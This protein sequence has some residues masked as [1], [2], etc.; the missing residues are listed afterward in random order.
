MR[1]MQSLTS[2][3]EFGGSRETLWNVEQSSPEM[4]YKIKKCNCWSC[5]FGLN[6]TQNQERTCEKDQD[7]GRKR[8]R[9]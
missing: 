7:D 5:S 4:S 2:F 9:T 3:R 1:G 6:R 8:V